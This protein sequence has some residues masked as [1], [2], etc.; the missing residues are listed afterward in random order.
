MGVGVGEGSVTALSFCLP[1]S[2][3]NLKTET[4]VVSVLPTHLLAPVALLVLPSR[5]AQDFLISPSEVPT[6]T[7]KA[8]L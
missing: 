8:K 6:V 3:L 2:L 7:P 4:G 1:P 5:L